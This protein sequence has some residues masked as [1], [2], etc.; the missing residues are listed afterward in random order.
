MSA[1]IVIENKKLCSKCGAVKL[2][3]EFYTNS[4]VS[5]GFNSQCKQCTNKSNT[6]RHRKVNGQV[7]EDGK[8]V[9]TTCNQ[10]KS[11]SEFYSHPSSVT[12]LSVSCKHCVDRCEDTRIQKTDKPVIRQQNIRD[13]KKWC[14]SCKQWKSFDDFYTIIPVGNRSPYSSYCKKC[15]R[16]KAKQYKTPEW[17]RTQNYKRFYGITIED[18]DQMFEDQVGCC[19]ICGTKEPGNTGKHFHVDHD[20]ETGI[21]RGLLCSHCNTALGL[22]KDNIESLEAAIQYLQAPIIWVKGFQAGESY[23]K[24]DQRRDKNYRHIHNITL[25][26][27]NQIFKS[28]NGQCAI[29]KTT[30]PGGPGGRLHIDHD[31]DTDKIR[32]LL[33][34]KCNSALGSFQDNPE[35]L[36]SA[37]QYL[38]KHN[39]YKL[40]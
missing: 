24:T 31:H 22:F 16:L 4:N 1:Q 2:T 14:P 39:A 21:I 32:G 6:K 8:K 33:C 38:E 36:K 19:T 5:S 34:S 11:V 20:H 7:I 17:Y 29:C 35:I 15:D 9:C 37:I 30:K 3:N 25:K 12:G 10:W 26:Q 23:S 28:Q 27:Y 40:V 18:Y 13:N